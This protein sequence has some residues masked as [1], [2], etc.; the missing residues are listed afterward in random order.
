M[1]GNHLVEETLKKLGAYEG[2]WCHFKFY[3]LGKFCWVKERKKD[4]WIIKSVKKSEILHEFL[5]DLVWAAYEF[6]Y[7][8][9]LDAE[10]FAR[11]IKSGRYTSK[12]SLSMKQAS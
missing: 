11:F 8:A 9:G 7:Y 12:F 6:D 1:P 5:E 3:V 10:E 2:D 4:I